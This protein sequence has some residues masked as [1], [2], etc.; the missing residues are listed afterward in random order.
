MR[1]GALYICLYS[2]VFKFEKEESASENIFFVRKRKADIDY[3]RLQGEGAIYLHMCGT[4]CHVCACLLSPVF[5]HR[6]TTRTVRMTAP[7]D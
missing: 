5:L 7:T 6:A 2:F 1:L 4:M 3:A